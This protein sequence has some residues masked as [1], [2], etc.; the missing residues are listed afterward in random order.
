[1]KRIWKTAV[2]LIILASA[3]AFAQSDAQKGLDRLKSL[4]GTWEGKNT[5]GDLVVDAYRLTAGGTAVMGEN[6]MGAEDMLSLFYVDGDRLLMT[7]F[8]PYGN[9]PRMQATISLDLKSI[10][11]NFLDATNLPDPRAGHM[12]Y[13]VYL[14]SDPDHYIE[15]WTWRQGGKDTTYQYEMQRKK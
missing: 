7:H 14:F 15:Q 10:F 11:F 4:A 3:T 9:Q 1:M 5:K 6:K 8:C 2:L 12:H 13:A